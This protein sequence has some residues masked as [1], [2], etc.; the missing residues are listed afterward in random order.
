M[1]GGIKHLQRLTRYFKR[2][3]IFPL[4]ILGLGPE[5]NGES[6]TVSLPGYVL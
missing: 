5:K 6:V 2:L 3:F 1:A 4:Y